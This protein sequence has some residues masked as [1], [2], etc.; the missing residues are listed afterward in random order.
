MPYTPLVDPFTIRFRKDEVEYEALVTYAKETDCCA[1]FF[2]VNIKVPAGIKPFQLKEKPTPGAES[3]SMIWVD[4]D[5]QVKM[6]YQIMGDEIEKYLRKDLG[7][8]LIDAP[9]INHEDDFSSREN[10]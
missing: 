10:D 6:L 2:D 3:E 9:V 5:D 4:K 1:N 7:I 8:I